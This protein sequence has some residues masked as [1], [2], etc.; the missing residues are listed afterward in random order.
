MFLPNHCETNGLILIL[1]PPGFPR[2]PLII[3]K[4]F[5][6]FNELPARGESGLNMIAQ[7]VDK[8]LNGDRFTRCPVEM[9]R[10]A[11]Q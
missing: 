4:P 6:H 7:Q 1:A 10:Y 9:C 2:K 8:A 5:M 11:T 3:D